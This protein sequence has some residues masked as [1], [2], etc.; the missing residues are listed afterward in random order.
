MRRLAV[1]WLVASRFVACATSGVP[2]NL[3]AFGLEPAGRMPVAFVWTRRLAVHE[4]APDNAEELASAEV[5]SDGRVLWIGT[6]RGVLWAVGARSGE[7][8]WKRRLGGAILS[9]PLYVPSRERLYVGSADGCLRALRPRDGAVLW[10]YCTDGAILRQPAYARGLVLFANERNRVY[11]VDAEHGRWKW[12]YDRPLPRGFTIHGHS[13]VTVADGKVYAGF[14]DGR[15][16]CLALG[17]GEVVWSRDLSE[18][19]EQY[20]DVDAKPVLAGGVL[21]VASYSGGV[22][23]LDPGLG[24][25]LWHFAVRAVTGVTVVDDRLYFVSATAGLHC[26]DLRGRLLYRQDLGDAGTPTRPVAAEDLLAFTTSRK[27][28]VFVNRETGRFVARIDDGFGAS[29]PVR[30]FGRRLF[31]LDNGGKLLAM[32]LY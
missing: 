19:H 28:L 17:T 22:Y 24:A 30:A 15:V 10:K 6:S 31:L 1:A 21:Y 7:V 2:Q 32:E 16:V 9:R 4:Y 5:R 27:G 11:A 25:L 29:A 18:G 26:L 3:G 13:P 12:S 14:A 8:L 20:V 23:A